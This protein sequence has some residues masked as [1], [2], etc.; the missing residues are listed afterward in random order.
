MKFH[1]RFWFPRSICDI[2]TPCSGDSKFELRNNEWLRFC[3]SWKLSPK[4]HPPAVPHSVSTTRRPK[5]HQCFSSQTHAWIPACKTH[6]GQTSKT[7]F[8]P[9][10]HP[11]KKKKNGNKGSN[12]QRSNNEEAEQA[13]RCHDRLPAFQDVNHIT[14]HYDIRPLVTLWH[15]PKHSIT[16]SQNRTSCPGNQYL[17]VITREKKK[18]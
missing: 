18:N 1:V 2:A 14:N 5:N 12:T 7:G 6:W 8:F 3:H 17:C 16:T 13:H 11:R 4:P 9:R 15:D 10:N